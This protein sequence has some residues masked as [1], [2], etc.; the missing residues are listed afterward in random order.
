MN[1]TL[2]RFRRLTAQLGRSFRAGGGHNWFLLALLGSAV[3]C[4]H[5]YILQN[6][7]DLLL[8]LASKLFPAIFES[9]SNSRQQ[10]QQKRASEEWPHSSDQPKSPGGQTGRG[11]I[12]RLGGKFFTHMAC[13]RNAHQCL[14]FPP[15]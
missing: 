11:R 15:H 13:A 9:P 14:F 3:L 1:V 7:C 8:K 5:G 2:L 12:G 4:T 10:Q 6:F